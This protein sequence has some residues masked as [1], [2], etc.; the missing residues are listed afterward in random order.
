MKQKQIIGPLTL[1]KFMAWTRK[2]NFYDGHLEGSP[3]IAWN[4]CNNIEKDRLLTEARKRCR[5]L[6][7]NSSYALL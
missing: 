7:V 1:A 3:E 6:H 2:F 4:R 5:R